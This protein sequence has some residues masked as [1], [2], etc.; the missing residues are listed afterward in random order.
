MLCKLD[1]IFLSQVS[2]FGRIGTIEQRIYPEVPFI[3]TEQIAY[4][5]ET[6]QIEIEAIPF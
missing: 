3:E 2:V 4:N 5:A 6:W 1:R